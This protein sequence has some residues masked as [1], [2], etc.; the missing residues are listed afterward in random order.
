VR[1]YAES[2]R[3]RESAQQHRSHLIKVERVDE[4]EWLRWETTCPTVGIEALQLVHPDGVH[5]DGMRIP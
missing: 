5:H 4:A 3:F 1:S 2:E